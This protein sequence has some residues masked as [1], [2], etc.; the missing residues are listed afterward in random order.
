MAARASGPRRPTNQT[1][2]M[3]TTACTRKATTFG[4]AKRASRGKG[5]APSIA[6]VRASMALSNKARRREP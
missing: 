1:S 4:A 5:G 2:A 6:W 3:L